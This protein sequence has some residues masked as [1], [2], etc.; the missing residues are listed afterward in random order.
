MP[1]VIVVGIVHYEAW[2]INELNSR[3]YVKLSVVVVVVVVVV[4]VISIDTD[5]ILS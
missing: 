3:F 4:D 1:Q 2:T 5:H